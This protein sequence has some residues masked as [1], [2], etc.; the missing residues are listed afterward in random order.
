MNWKFI[1]A[2]VICPEC[3]NG[4]DISFWMKGLM[5]CLSFICKAC[6][7]R[8]KIIPPEIEEK[9]CAMCERRIDCLV[10]PPFIVTRF[11]VNNEHIEIWKYDPECI[12]GE[13]GMR[14]CHIDDILINGQ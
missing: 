8:Y 6:R 12:D 4:Y 7:G 10:D 2:R 11:R 9:V 5:P 1:A 14:D 3:K 13:K